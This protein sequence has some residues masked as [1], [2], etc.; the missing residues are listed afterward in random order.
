MVL[1]IPKY[2]ADVISALE[3]EG[4]EA[5]AVGGCVRDALLGREPNDW[6]VTTSALPEAVNGLFSRLNGYTA[7][8]TGVA[9]GTVTVLSGGMPVEVT[10]YRID[11]EYTDFR[12]PDSV[13]FCRELPL[14]LARRDFTVN[15]MAY[16]DRSG[17][18]DLYGGTDDLKNRVIRCVGDPERR[19]TEDALRILRALR[20]SATLGFAIEHETANAAVK[21]RG[22]LS[23]VSRERI[24]SELG[25]LI[26]QS[27]A[28]AAVRDFEDIFREILPGLNI[29]KKVVSSVERL[30][31]EPL[32]LMLA[33]LFGDTEAG[34]IPDLLRFCRFDN[35][36]VARIKAISNS[37]GAVL[38]GKADVKRLCRDIGMAASEDA[39]RLGVARDELEKTVLDLILE[40]KENGEC[41]SV[42]G[43]AV[44]GEDLLALG[45]AP[46]DIGSLL[47]MLLDGV[48]EGNIKNER[49]ALIAA[50]KRQTYNCLEK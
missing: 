19:F 33:A 46:R 47:Y 38:D 6:D 31:G 17:L 21:L 15:A 27:G 29:T 48:I 24:G 18:V 13:E 49:D 4:Y 25:K 10:T 44:R 43:L 23:H 3:N 1:E 50:A 12:R 2:A 5:Y 37:R 28:A 36:T 8:P 32:A 42:A 40:V 41:V 20:F 30:H 34:K 22:L 35:K 45:V 16:S 14:D 26:C 9:H 11:G 7:I 39:V